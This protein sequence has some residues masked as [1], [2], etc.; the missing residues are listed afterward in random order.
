MHPETRRER[1][2]EGRLTAGRRRYRCLVISVVAV[3]GL[4]PVLGGGA[5]ALAA[6]PAPA[7]TYQPTDLVAVAHGGVQGYCYWGELQGPPDD[8][9]PTRL[10][11]FTCDRGYGIPIYEADGV[12][13][14]GTFELGGPG[15]GGGGSS[16]DGSRRE[17]TAD[18]H[19][20]IIEVKR[21]ATRQITI[22]RTWLSGATTT[23][24]AAADP[25]LSRIPRAERPVTWQA[26][27]LWFRGTGPEHPELTSTRPQAPAWL[28]GRMSAAARA[29]GDPDA[30]ARWTLTFRRCAAPLEGAS[31]PSTDEGKY[32]IVWIAVLHGAFTD[33]SWSYL[34]L[35]R[36]SHGV[37]SQGVS[38]TPFDT[39]MLRL[40]GRTQLH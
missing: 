32:K 8:I 35:D 38:Q 11:Q 21:S 23:N 34:I 24:T 40:Q 27:M 31:A 36:G 10:V 26:I 7:P 16:P 17:E 1:S 33:G 25:S 15:S 22:T 4:L 14:I 28:G 12:T 18:S 29:A 5:S 3:A 13:R 19:G 2:C 6:A 39:S 9:L 37:I 30:V 20:T